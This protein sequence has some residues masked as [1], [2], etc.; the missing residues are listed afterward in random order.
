MATV[1]SDDRSRPSLDFADRTAA[2]SEL[3][4][5]FT[6]SGYLLLRGLIDETAIT[7]AFAQISAPLVSTRWCSLSDGGRGLVPVHEATG[8]RRD[9][10]RHRDLY[11][12]VFS[13]EALHLLGRSRALI[14]MMETLLNTNDLVVHP[15]PALRLEFPNTDGNDSD[16]TPPHQDHLGMQASPE[17]LTAWIALVT[18]PVEMGPIEVA[19]GSHRAGLRAY[20]AVAGSRVLACEAD[21]LAGRFTTTDLL[22]GDVVIFHSLT[23]H[24][25]RAN[26]SDHVRLSVDFRYQSRSEPICEATLRPEADLAWEGARKSWLDQ[27]P[28][29]LDHDG[30]TVV[31]LDPTFAFAR[32]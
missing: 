14:E 3:R 6:R 26:R 12:E 21:D 22:A 16:V 7:N 15:R 23:V 29:L 31:P 28:A 11:R 2:P 19:P 4:S 20:R 27:R 18:C 32:P 13:C 5:R 25:T 8:A 24:R 1:G 9:L 30:M 10:Y 17:V